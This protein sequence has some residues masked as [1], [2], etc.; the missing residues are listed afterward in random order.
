MVTGQT[1]IAF[2]LASVTSREIKQNEEPARWNS[3]F[4]ALVLGTISI[5][6]L[7]LN[8][9]KPLQTTSIVAAFPLMFILI[10]VAAS[11]FK[12]MQT[13][14]YSKRLNSDKNIIL[15]EDVKKNIQG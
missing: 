12:M 2:T 6:L 10:I 7:L 13:D 11:F 14:G 8:A 1:T 15:P 9:L 4:W 5:S 3:F